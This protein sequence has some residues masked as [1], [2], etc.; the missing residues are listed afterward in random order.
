MRFFE[1][2][3]KFQFL[4]GLIIV[5]G[6]LLL[7]P[8]VSAQTT[9]ELKKQQEQ[10]QQKLNQIQ[11]KIDDFQNQIS[12]T[13]KQS[14]TLK[15][16]I[17]VFDKQIT[18]LELQMEANQTQS[19]DTTLQIKETEN[20]INR[21]QA[22]IA[23]N[24]KILGELIVQLNEM[25]GSSLLYMGLGNDNFSAFLDQVQYAESVSSKVYE[26]L[27]NIKIVKAKLEAQKVELEAQLGRLEELREQ[28]DKTQ[29]AVNEQRSQKE[30]LLN[31][32]RG[33]ERNYQRLLGQSKEEKD[34]AQQEIDDLDAAIRAKLGNLAPPKAV[35]AFAY[36]MKG[37]LTQ[38][39]G[40]TG[41]TALGYNFHNGIDIAAPP[42]TPIYAAGDGVVV[43]CDT[44]EAAYG[45]W[46][47]IKHTLAGGRQLITLYAHMSSFSQQV[48]Q[49]DL[50]GYEGNTGN[51]TRLTR[52]AG[53]G[54]HIHFG[55][56]D[57]Q[58]F[59]INPGA[60]TSIYGHYSVPY[61]YTYNPFD[62]LPR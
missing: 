41:F 54:Y 26:I 19:E 31:Q 9:D 4:A 46:C 60:H 36:P 43:A 45:N 49:G 17:S 35:G 23:D 56:F 40:K 8:S 5:T 59:G 16:Q 34:K 57:A 7:I 47:A 12:D 48:K 62:F 20:Q 22:E 3:T 6:L 13:Q 42:N 39:Y 30:G 53:F 2:K 58:G 44:G 28:L 51:T 50:V 21:R 33:L 52:G 15:N 32:T 37:V 24:K 29:S 10:L 38:G 61:G 27:Q 55:F 11:S 1:I 18:S 14:N 25:D